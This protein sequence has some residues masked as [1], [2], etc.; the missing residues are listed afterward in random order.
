MKTTLFRAQGP[1]RE[2]WA[3]KSRLKDL[4]GSVDGLDQ[5]RF[6]TRVDNDET[7]AAVDAAK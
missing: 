1:E 5:A 4:A 2:V 3:T 7:A 6:A